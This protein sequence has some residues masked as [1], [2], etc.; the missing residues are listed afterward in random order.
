MILGWDGLPIEVSIVARGTEMR[1]LRHI[2]LEHQPNACCVEG[3]HPRYPFQ[4]CGSSA[5]GPPVI[6]NRRSVTYLAERRANNSLEIDPATHM[7]MIVSN[8]W[9]FL[10]VEP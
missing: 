5:N 1:S 10:V 3:Q 8:F 2:L 6:C 7:G 9:G 4:T